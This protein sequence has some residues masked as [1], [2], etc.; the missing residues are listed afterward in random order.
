MH[1]EPLRLI[2]NEMR[3]KFIDELNKG[4]KSEYKVDITGDVCP[5]CRYVQREFMKRYNGDIQ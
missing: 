5:A 1:E 2:P 3:Q 4:S